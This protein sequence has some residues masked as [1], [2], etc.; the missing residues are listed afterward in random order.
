MACFYVV[1]FKLLSHARIE[2]LVIGDVSAKG[3]ISIGFKA[4]VDKHTTKNWNQECAIFSPP[5][6]Q[7]F[8][9]IIKLALFSQ[10][11]TK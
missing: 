11:K 5:P 3:K 7:F 9:F 10:L 4:T 2:A 1:I 8:L 6:H